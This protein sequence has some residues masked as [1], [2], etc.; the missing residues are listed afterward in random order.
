MEQEKDERAA[1]F[2]HLAREQDRLAAYHQ[3]HAVWALELAQHLSQ[4]IIRIHSSTRQAH[5]NRQTDKCYAVLGGC[6]PNDPLHEIKAWG[7]REYAANALLWDDLISRGADEEDSI[8]AEE[9][10][11]RERHSFHI[12]EQITAEGNAK[13]FRSFK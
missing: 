8:R 4:H 10:R 3:H 6:P 5:F 1:L 11:A 13:W 12:A 2:E 7:T 9:N